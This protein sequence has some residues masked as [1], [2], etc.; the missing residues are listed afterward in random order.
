MAL[1]AATAAVPGPCG[2]DLRVAVADPPPASA[3]GTTTVHA[4]VTNTGDT[5]TLGPFTL[6]VHLPPGVVGT[7]LAPAVC[8]TGPFGHTVTCTFPAGLAAGDSVAADVRLGVASGMDPGTLDGT[9]EADQPAD[10]T[11]AD[12]SARFAIVVR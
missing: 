8:S 11:P 4:V 7:G 10:P 2:P 3:G 5:T 9:V 1:G 6:V 12:N